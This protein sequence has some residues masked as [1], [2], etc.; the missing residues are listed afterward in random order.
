MHI[1]SIKKLT[2]LFSF[3]ML[4][5]L[6]S[7]MIFPQFA[8]GNTGTDTIVKEFYTHDWAYE[9]PTGTQVIARNSATSS[10]PSAAQEIICELDINA[11]IAQ[12]K[13]WVSWGSALR[14]HTAW[15]YYS[16]DMSDIVN[17][18]VVGMDVRFAAGTNLENYYVVI[19]SLEGASIHNYLGRKIS[20]YYSEDDYGKT[21]TIQIPLSE[22]K[23][24]DDKITYNTLTNHS[25]MDFT[26]F[27]YVGLAWAD[28]N[29]TGGKETSYIDNIRVYNV[30]PPQ[31]ARISDGTPTTLT[32][33][34]EASTSNI[35]E[36]EIHRNDGVI[37]HVSSGETSYTDNNLEMQTNYSYRLRA[38]DPYGIYSK[39]T[40]SIS[41]YTIPIDKPS[42]F[43]VT[44]ILGSLATELT[45][46]APVQGNEVAKY[47]I[48]RD[49]K[50]IAEVDGDETSY[51]DEVG[52]IANTSYSYYMKSTDEYENVSYA[53]AT[54]NII[55]TLVNPPVNFKVSPIPNIIATE[56]TWEKPAF[57]KVT[58]DKYE[59]Y[60]NDDLID[61]VDGNETSY[62][63]SQ[64]LMD[65]KEYEYFI[66]SVGDEGSR[67]LPSNSISVFVR[68]IDPPQEFKVIGGESLDGY[69]NVE[70]EEVQLTWKAPS[71]GNVKEYQLYRNDELIAII[72]K[73]ATS[74]TDKNG[75]IDENVYTYYMLSI[76][77]GN[78][79]SRP[80]TETIKV[81]MKIIGVPQNFTV[82]SIEG[83]T[84]VQ[85]TWDEPKYGTVDK[86]YIYRD[87]NMIAEIDGT[88]TS[89][90]DNK[91][92]LNNTTYTY[93][94]TSIDINGNV[95][96][97][98]EEKSIQIRAID[99]PDEFKA[100]AVIDTTK[101]ELTWKSPKYGIVD[102]YLIY[103]D[104]EL[105]AEVDSTVTSYLDEENLVNENTYSYYLRCVDVQG[106]ISAKTSTVTVTIKAIG[107]PQNLT[108][109][110]VPDS[111]SARITWGKPSYGQVDK[112]YIYRNDGLNTRLIVE[113]DSTETSYIDQEG[114][115]DNTYYYYS[116]ICIDKEGNVSLPTYIEEVFVALI[117]P[118]DGLTVAISDYDKRYISLGWQRVVNA[119]S[120]IV[121]CNGE[122]ITETNTLNFIH[123]NLEYDT[124]YA[125]SVKAKRADGLLSVFSRP[126]EV[127][128]YGSEWINI[129]TPIIGET[130][131][132]EATEI[133][134]KEFSFPLNYFNNAPSLKEL[135]DSKSGSLC[136][137]I[138]MPSSQ[139]L[140]NMSVGF[141]YVRTSQLTIR[142]MVSLADYYKQIG[143][144]A[145]IEIPLSDFPVKG[146]FNSLN[147]TH[148][149]LDIFDYSAANSIVIKGLL[150]NT[151]EDFTIRLAE[152]RLFEYKAPSVESIT[153]ENDNLINKGS[154][155]SVNTDKLNIKF[156]FDMDPETLNSNSVKIRKSGG[157]G[158]AISIF[159][160][161][162]EIKRE[163]NLRMLE[164]L[165]PET[166][167]E[168]SV[169]GVKSKRGVQIKNTYKFSFVTNDEEPIGEVELPKLKVQLSNANVNIG[170]AAQISVT[171]NNNNYVCGLSMKIKYDKQILRINSNSVVLENQLLNKGATVDINTLGIIKIN[172]PTDNTNSWILNGKLF[173]INFETHT[174]GNTILDLE[175]T[176]ILYNAQR[177]MMTNINIEGDGGG[178][179]NIT[180]AEVNQKDG[181]S[182]IGGG[183]GGRTPVTAAPSNNIP[184]VITEPVKN[185]Q[186]VQMTDVSE[187]AWAEE[188][189]KYLVEH[190]YIKGYPDNTFKPNQNITREEFVTILVNAFKLLDEEANDGFSDVD[191][192]QWYFK[193]I[194]SAK[195][196]GII[197]GMGDG[198]FGVGTNITRQDACA[199]LYR[200]A[201]KT[202][203][204]PTP[205][206]DTIIFDD[207]NDIDDYAL[208]AIKI[209]QQ[210]GI[211]NG[212]G[213]NE[214]DP[215][216]V[217]N[218]AMAAKLVHGLIEQKY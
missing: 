53:T 40:E 179:I 108:V 199:M 27:T 156:D 62:I 82:S 113:L 181:Y 106:N 21:K 26:K 72:N 94:M 55:V 125:Y 100:T 160:T 117:S 132:I 189:I 24:V 194:A 155:I 56:L 79:P 98:T 153:D 107:K 191:E 173:K 23:N 126:S 85:L 101:V 211:V 7:T 5:F 97:K 33:S 105:I 216:G 167:Y 6:I 38:K 127:V 19:A 161:Y 123:K 29:A 77:E 210:S 11:Q 159:G 197:S 59:I 25:P 202:E 15:V 131:T 190:E 212:V 92:L 166:I 207:Q 218:R 121:Y 35:V 34:W 39:Y 54:K 37:K 134:T 74:Y 124:F 158:E 204:M 119:I 95:S 149:Y 201:E 171:S 147:H 180:K 96:K 61:V 195:E 163:Y 69:V 120:Y 57:G 174:H 3:V 81:R 71:Y 84:E 146:E 136:L 87:G 104:E 1:K 148:T 176:T 162:D 14:N 28:P 183:G 65:S 45:W 154:T 214:F 70:G 80:T 58:I 31:R 41:G 135:Y 143:E 142:S 51:V 152:L 48:Y 186:S 9:S 187:L 90:D 16:M 128:I 203:I 60:R 139:N 109:R 150:E 12:E 46:E 217:V 73:D 93:Y 164:R 20:D 213:N 110:S 102:R 215:K 200:V 68:A 22:F 206:Y 66:V 4:V 118:P 138:H 185:V 17:T 52:L 172:V 129:I 116:I 2:T 88:V 43:V 184:V 32:I 157:S 205:V 91:Y 115:S 36:Y 122:Q 64:N 78:I 89:Y 114:L 75:F 42:N 112:Y 144:Y 137:I 182:P 47:L 209:M 99:R 168:I 178:N 50:L 133:G 49:D 177:D 10:S 86:Y 111:I 192:S 175:G 44:D 145:F 170:Q 193:Y 18:G 151:S 76:S 83:S 141:S 196:A 130:F 208:D 8:E 30:N 103:R 67:S 165:S 140:E 188:S 198:T 169:Q 13:L 63:D